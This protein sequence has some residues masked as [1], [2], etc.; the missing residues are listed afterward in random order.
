[1]DK[2]VGLCLCMYD[3]TRLTLDVSKHSLTL[4]ECSLLDG[5]RS[6][7]KNLFLL[8]ILFFINF[9]ISDFYFGFKLKHVNGTVKW[10]SCQG[11]L[12]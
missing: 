8:L 11:A 6:S 4:A 10:L 2:N 3:L 1:M 7:F 12:I 5:S 9:G